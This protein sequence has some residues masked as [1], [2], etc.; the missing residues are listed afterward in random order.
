MYLISNTFAF[1]KN[2]QSKYKYK[3]ITEFTVFGFKI[4]K[5]YIGVMES[6]Y[7]GDIFELELLSVLGVTEINVLGFAIGNGSISL[8]M[9]FCYR[10]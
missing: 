6:D 7:I 8:Q 4:D 3:A 2:S 1:S 9:S 5:K 10:K